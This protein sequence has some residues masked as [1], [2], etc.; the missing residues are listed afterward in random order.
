MRQMQTLTW[1][2]DIANVSSF[3]HM[4]GLVASGNELVLAR[5]PVSVGA[6]GGT[7]LGHRGT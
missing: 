2:A 5:L 3:E 4:A 1:Q 7:R 6:E